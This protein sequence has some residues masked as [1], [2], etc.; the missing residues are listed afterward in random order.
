VLREAG[1][2]LLAAGNTR[3]EPANAVEHCYLKGSVPVIVV[4]GD[5]RDIG[6]AGS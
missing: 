2:C 4:C 3:T 5:S 6:S 1:L